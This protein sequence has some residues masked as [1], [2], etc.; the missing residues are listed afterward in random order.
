MYR[1][2]EIAPLLLSKHTYIGASVYEILARASLLP[3]ARQIQIDRKV[4]LLPIDDH[5]RAGYSHTAIL[6]H[7]MRT[8]HLRPRYGILRAKNEVHYAGKSLRYRK[9]HPRG[10][11]CVVRDLEE[12][13]IV[14]DIITTGTTLLEA[15]KALRKAGAQPLFAVTLADAREL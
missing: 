4:T 6:A 13:V 15:S 5:I 14:D 2:H 7:A 12:T 1:Y 9:S 3:F 11:T 8:P 10:F